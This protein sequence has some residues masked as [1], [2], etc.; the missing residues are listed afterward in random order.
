MTTPLRIV[1]SSR[2]SEVSRELVRGHLYVTVALDAEGT[3]VPVKATDLEVMQISAEEAF[4]LAMALLRRT[5]AISDL[6]PVDTLPG[7][8]F[9]VAGDGLAASRMVL[10]P[11]MFEPAPLG[12]VVIAVPGPDQ[13]LCVPLD[14]ARALDALQVLAS[15]L[16]HA[17]SALENP[18]SDQMFW[19]DGG[20]WIPVAVHHGDEDITV[21]PPA[22]FVRTMNHLAAMDMVSVAGEA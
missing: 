15:A 2:P 13:L 10:L 16:G 3:L 1:M 18:L 20:R 12:G 19:F 14:S 9:L 11:E 8:Q 7:L 21:L 17:S 4:Q 6:R 22:A 5:T